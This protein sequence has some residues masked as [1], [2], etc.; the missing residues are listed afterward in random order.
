MRPFDITSA[1]PSADDFKSLYDTTGW[2]PPCRAADFYRAALVG[3]WHSASAYSDGQL[4]GF[5]RV[6]SDGH[7][8]AFITEMIVRPDHQ[9]RGI[10]SGL[11][12]AVLDACHRAGIG[13]IQLFCAK[14]KAPFY[15]RHGFVERP[16]DAPGMQFQCKAGA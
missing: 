7:L 4:V 13:D 9:G 3:S 10:G 6:I 14:G 5:A 11:L 15:A 16:D 8:H 1:A 2:G 12:A